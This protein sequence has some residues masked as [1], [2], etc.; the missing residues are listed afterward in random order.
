[1]I[2]R[3]PRS[4]PLYSSASSDVYK[5]QIKDHLLCPV[6]QVNRSI[7]SAVPHVCD[8][9]PHVYQGAEE[10]VLFDDIRVVASIG[11]RRYGGDQ[12]MNKGATP[13][14][15]Q[16]SAVAQFLTDRDGIHGLTLRVQILYNL[17]DL[18]VRSSVEVLGPQNLSHTCDQ[19][20]RNQKRAQPDRR[21]D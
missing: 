13:D 12:T 8:F 1:M 18:T 7:L 21:C 15:L 16:G 14:L 19:V 9:P 20:G 6:D 2:R 10:I 17:V 5:R 11:G 4:T 3:P